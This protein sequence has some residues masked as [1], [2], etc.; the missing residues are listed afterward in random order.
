LINYWDVGKL[1]FGRLWRETLNNDLI[2]ELTFGRK[3]RVERFER[4]GRVSCSDKEF[5]RPDFDEPS[6]GHPIGDDHG[7]ST[8]PHSI[9]PTINWFAE[10][11]IYNLEDGETCEKTCKRQIVEDVQEETR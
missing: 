2:T 1:R 8:A 4:Y 7:Q 6:L 3:Q 5:Y 11:E 9:E 10:A